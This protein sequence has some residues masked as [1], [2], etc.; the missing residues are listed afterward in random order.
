MKVLHRVDLQRERGGMETYRAGEV[1]EV[2]LDKFEAV[3]MA[4]GDGCAED[5]DADAEPEA[6]A[7]QKLPDPP[8]PEPEPFELDEDE[9]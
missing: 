8:Q 6:E 9:E 7:D 4:G 5:E 1:Y 3:K 2:D